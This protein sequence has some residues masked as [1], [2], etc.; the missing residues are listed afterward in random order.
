LDVVFGGEFA[1][2]DALTRADLFINAV[3]YVSGGILAVRS[4]S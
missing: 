1:D 4:D 3:C 2:G